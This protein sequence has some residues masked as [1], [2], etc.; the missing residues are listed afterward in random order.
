MRTDGQ[1]T[2]T[3]LTVAF[4][5]FA[6][7]TK[8]SDDLNHTRLWHST[9]RR[10]LFGRHEV[11]DGTL[12]RTLTVFIYIRRMPHFYL[13]QVAVIITGFIGYVQSLRTK[14]GIVCDI[15]A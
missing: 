15:R 7:A 6:N 13:G 8:N 12:T 14:A 1:T 5:N 3:K 11:S 4:R 2:M 10:W 9:D